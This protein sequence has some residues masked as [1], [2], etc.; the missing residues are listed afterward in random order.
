[1]YVATEYTE[2]GFQQAAREQHMSTDSQWNSTML[3]RERKHSLHLHKWPAN[4]Q[5]CKSTRAC[6]CVCMCSC[7]DSRPCTRTSHTVYRQH[8]KVACY[9][10]TVLERGGGCI[11][12]Q[13]AFLLLLASYCNLK[14]QWWTTWLYTTTHNVKLSWENYKYITQSGVSTLLLI[15]SWAC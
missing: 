12:S 13:K 14:L 6:V 11:A 10:D 1:M 2:W 9:S 3:Q 8:S 7:E 4:A 15:Q 5:V